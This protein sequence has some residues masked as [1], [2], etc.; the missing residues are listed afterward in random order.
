[1]PEG[2]PDEA[3]R[4]PPPRPTTRDQRQGRSVH[5]IIGSASPLISTPPAHSTTGGEFADEVGM[6]S[7]VIGAMAHHRLSAVRTGGVGLT[8]EPVRMYQ[9]SHLPHRTEKRILA[10]TLSRPW[11]S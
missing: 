1:M 3:N 7:S 5:H 8:S 10:G 6:S 9:L 11:A 4:S 2:C